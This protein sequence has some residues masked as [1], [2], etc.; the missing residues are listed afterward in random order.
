MKEFDVVQVT[1]GF[2]GLSVGDF[3]WVKKVLGGT[4]LIMSDG[5]RDYLKQ[6]AYVTLW[7]SAP[8]A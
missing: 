6:D 4:F 5:T 2:S 1:I 3:L 7:A 8:E